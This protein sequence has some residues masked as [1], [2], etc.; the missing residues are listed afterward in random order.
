MANAISETDP[1]QESKA[2]LFLPNVGDLLFVGVCQL[3]LFM[4]PT[5]IFSDG[6]TGW[7]LATGFKILADHAIPHQDFLSYTFPGKDWVAYEWLSDLFMAGLVHLGGL[8][9]LAVIVTISLASLTL[10]LYQKVREGGSNFLLALFFSTVGLLTAAIHWLVRPHIFTFWGVYLFTTRLEAFYSGKR[11]FKWLAAWLLP[12]MVLW[13]NC[14]PAFLLAFAI[15][16]LYLL[17]VLLRGITA[18]NQSL[19]Q[20]KLKQAGQLALLLMLLL[21]VSLAN[22]YGLTLY[23]YIGEYLHGTSILAQTDEFKPPNFLLNFHAYCLAILMA[24]ASVGLCFGRNKLSLPALALTIIFA[25]LALSAVRHMPLFVIVVLPVL[26]ILYSGF[27]FNAAKT[28]ALLKSFV[29]GAQGFD[30]EEKKSNM[31]LLPWLYSIIIIIIALATPQQ[32][33]EA[34]LKAGFDDKL[35]PSKTLD[36]IA[37]HKLPAVGG[38]NFDNWGG[39]IR[40]KLGMPVYIDDRADFYGEKFYGEYG[41]ICETRPGWHQ[42]LELR[43]INWILFPKDSG[44]IKQLKERKDWSTACEDE[45]A[46]LMVKITKN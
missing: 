45:A 38:F 10:A 33:P 14:H 28:P 3:L 8:N 5:F 34:M 29:A 4:R 32:G 19:R 42:L 43:K 39:L 25:Y 16:G 21:L 30:A 11:S 6:S 13:V 31:H 24:F 27:Q 7:H 23:H 20:G 40:Y 46:T 18:D 2:A 9:L 35:A 41:I 15:T 1:P 17:I 44:L 37:A 22:P 12:Y 36:Y 26:G